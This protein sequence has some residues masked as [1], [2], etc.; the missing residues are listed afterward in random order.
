MNAM[1]LSP[2]VNISPPNIAPAIDRKPSSTAI[3]VPL[4][5]L[6]LLPAIVA[7]P[8]YSVNLNSIYFRVFSTV[9][10]YLDD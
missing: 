6:L 7:P 1:N 2:S 5:I 9:K 8:K 4:R 3:A 10:Q